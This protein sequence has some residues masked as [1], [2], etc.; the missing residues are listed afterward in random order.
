MVLTGDYSASELK[1][2][3]N[4]NHLKGSVTAKIDENIK[5]TWKMEHDTGWGMKEKEQLV[6]NKHNQC[7]CMV[8]T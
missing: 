5:C 1:K 3:L 6:Q 8:C 2:A 4:N 7:V